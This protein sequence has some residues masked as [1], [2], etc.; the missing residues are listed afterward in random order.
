[1][2]GF[3]RSNCF[4]IRFCDNST[5]LPL[6]LSWQRRNHRHFAAIQSGFMPYRDYDIT[7]RSIFLFH[8]EL[9]PNF[10]AL[11]PLAYIISRKCPSAFFSMR[12]TCT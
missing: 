7:K 2:R 5:N 1:M 9:V 3:I 10:A 12:E 11:H 4:R 6:F 8:F